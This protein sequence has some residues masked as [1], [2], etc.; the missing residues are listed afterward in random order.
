PV[1]LFE[2]LVFGL[3]LPERRGHT[4]CGPS[5][6][7][8]DPHS[9]HIHLL[10]GEVLAFQRHALLLVLLSDASNQQALLWRTGHDGWALVPTSEQPV[11]VV[12]AKVAC[13]L[14]IGGV[15]VVTVVRENRSDLL[16]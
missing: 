10:V 1:F 8:L 12:H 3:G 2:L 14:G 15:A 6:T 11:A 16:L 5:G 4:H 13:G 9:E 7:V